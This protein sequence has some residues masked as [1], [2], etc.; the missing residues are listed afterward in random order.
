MMTDAD[1]DTQ[2]LTET[3]AWPDT[4]DSA[5]TPAED[6]TPDRPTPDRGDEQTPDPGDEQT[7]D[8]ENQDATS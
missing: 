1:K 5:V 7:P 4:L 6:I 2:A 3:E 8:S